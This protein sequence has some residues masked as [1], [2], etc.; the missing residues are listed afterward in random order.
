MQFKG[1][2]GSLLTEFSGSR[3]SRQGAVKHGVGEL[4]ERGYVEMVN[5][6]M[7]LGQYYGHFLLN[8]YSN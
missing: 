7:D 5:N 3:I 8:Y 2:G 6:L 1:S 4:L